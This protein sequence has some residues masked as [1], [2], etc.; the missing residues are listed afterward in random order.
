MIKLRQIAILGRWMMSHLL[1]V[2][3][4]RQSAR[5]RGRGVAEDC[6]SLETLATYVDHNLGEAEVR[7]IEG[8]LAECHFCRRLVLV[9]VQSQQAVPDPVIPNP[10]R[11]RSS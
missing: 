9:V 7:R 5:K 8:H 3:W 11:S 4:C 2:L 6:P 10:R 1:K